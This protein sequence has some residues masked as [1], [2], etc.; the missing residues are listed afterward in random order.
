MIFNL[1]SNISQ[2][3]R[4]LEILQNTYWK[5]L[6]LSAPYI[7]NIEQ[8]VIDPV[9]KLLENVKNRNIEV[10]VY[11]KRDV[12]PSLWNNNKTKKSVEVL[13]N[14]TEINWNNKPIFNFAWKQ[15]SAA[16]PTAQEKVIMQK[17]ISIPSY[18]VVTNTNEMITSTSR[19]SQHNNIFTWLYSKFAENFWHEDNGPISMALFFLNKEDANLYMH[20]LVGKSNTKLVEKSR[21]RLYK[22]TLAH[23]YYLNR[24]NKIGQQARIVADL[25]ELEKVIFSHI[26]SKLQNPNIK[27]SHSKNGFIGTP[28]Y[29][30]SATSRKNTYK[31]QNQEVT[32]KHINQYMNSIFFKLEDAY[33]AWE[34]ICETNK[35]AKLE[36]RP[37]IEIYN[38]ENYL[39][40]LE[41]SP[42]KVLAEIKFRPSLESVKDVEKKINLPPEE[43]NSSGS[44]IKKFIMHTIKHEKLLS[45]YKGILWVFTSDNLPTEDN[46]W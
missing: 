7:Y 40:D 15:K 11:S 6:R 5:K 38:L 35:N 41:K 8:P 29:T 2:S 18:V 37:N 27:Q 33:L 36:A 3:S 24:T 43:Q 4:E 45:F 20:S 14:P 28:I 22:T 21:L 12:I 31:Q 19:D 46:A 26:P 10:L 9:A 32:R 34:K 42:L 1:F 25:K 30:I 17:L 13:V 39:L 23:F 16:F 44:G